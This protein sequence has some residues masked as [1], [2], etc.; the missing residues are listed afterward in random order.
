[1]SAGRALLGYGKLGRAIRGER[2]RTNEEEDGAIIV[3]EG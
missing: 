3:Q 1:M 2:K